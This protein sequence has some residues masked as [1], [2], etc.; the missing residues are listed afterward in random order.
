MALPSSFWILAATEG[1]MA[2]GYAVSFP[3]LAV[4][5]N[6][7][8]GLPMSWTGAFLAFSMLVSSAAQFAGG[9]V[10][11]AVGR[12]KV[13]V[14]SLALRTLNIGAIAFAIY[15]AWPLWFIFAVHPLGMLAGGFFHP[16]ARAWVAD[17]T[18]PAGRM[19]AY[20]FLRMGMNA[21]W[22]L[23]PALGGLLAE[24]SYSVMF[25]V[26]AAV[27]AVCTLIVAF[28]VRDLP[29]PPRAPLAVS[30]LSGFGSAL[31]DRNFLRFCVFTFTM[32]A[33]MSQLVVSASLYSKSFLGFSERDIGLLFSING[34]MVVA[35]QYFV[36]RA[37][38]G[39]RITGGLA[40]GARLYAAGYLAFGYSPSFFFAAA[41]MVIITFGELAVSPGMQAMGAN[42]APRAAKG[43]YLGVQ[44]VFEQVG[45][46]A[47][48]FA[49]SNAI[50]L[51][52]PHFPEGPWFMVAAVAVVSC[53][54]FLSLGRRLTREQDG[55][56]GPVLPPPPGE[57]EPALGL[58]TAK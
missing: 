36:T 30:G 27:F 12:R 45:K 4:Y 37:L 55:L 50:G 29:G 58:P 14:W 8:R 23:G 15:G 21:G 1:L 5:L 52:S 38:E 46:S 49:G 24:G 11:D 44:G 25:F 2:A 54:G 32:S 41:A 34:S 17:Q 39:R 47:G 42:M 35:F 56:R 33:V 19:K 3:F 13:M 31:A 48:I 9:E 7:Q 18:P 40:A 26:T 10:S 57:A 6:T 16:A 53:F 22:A 20:G 51:M 43:R 28:S